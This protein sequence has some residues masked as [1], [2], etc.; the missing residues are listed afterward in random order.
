[1]RERFGTLSL[2]AIRSLWHRRYT[3]SLLIVSIML[4]TAL[5]LAVERLRSEMRESFANTVSGTDLLVGARSSPIQLLMYAIFHKGNATQNVSWETYQAFSNHPKVA[6]TIPLSLGDSHKGF[7]VIGTTNAFFEHYRYGQKRSL[8]VDGAP[9]F[10]GLYDTV[11]GA[12][13]AEAL[14]YALND[15]IIIAHGLEDIGFSRHGNHPFRVTGIMQRTGTPIDNAVLV[16]LDALEAIHAGWKP[17][18]FLN[19][20][21]SG[22]GAPTLS[23]TTTPTANAPVAVLTPTSITAFLVGLK[24][25]VAIFQVQR[26]IND[27]REEALLAV[28][29]GVTLMDLWNTLAIV[30]TILLALSIL[31]TLISLIGMVA[32]MLATLNERRREMALLR[33]LGAHASDILFLIVGEALLTTLCAVTLSLGFFNI[34]VLVG[35]NWLETTYSLQLSVGL[36]SARE[37]L[38]LSGIVMAGVLGSVLPAIRA[39]RQSLIDGLTPG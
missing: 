1:M 18:S 27:Y 26:A 28:V 22:N 11:I 2:L 7:R 25:R 30:E 12:A 4:G 20:G 39:Y 17:G 31:V 3:V 6:W 29:P 5:L 8:S 32:L 14:G 35:G 10:S 13:V 21:L 34:A 16:G 9:G 19:N 37:W 36:P 23:H 24:S 33:A 15:E 38:I